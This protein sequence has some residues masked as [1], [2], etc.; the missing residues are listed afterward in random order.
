MVFS[1]GDFVK[2]DYSIWRQADRM[3]IYT[4][5]KKL[6]EENNAFDN[7]TTYGPQLVVVGK[8]NVIKGVDSAIKSMGVSESRKLELEPKDAFG[9][10]NPD[11]IKV[12]P[13]NDFRKKDI[14]PY[15][16]MQ[17]D[18]DG[19][20][21]T[22]KSV[23][24]GRVTVDANHPLAGEKL[25]CEIK[26]TEKVDKDDDKATALAEKFALK[27]D[28]VAITGSQIKFVFG[29]KTDKGSKYLVSKTDLVN[30]TM[31]YMDKIDRIVVEE[32]FA[33]PKKDEQKGSA[34]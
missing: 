23:T 7:E 34:K 19:S 14:A 2:I 28:S 13:L 20:V 24:S 10:K 29:D 8:G 12:M 30:A 11:L 22:V 27:P 6:A 31:A 26:V 32:E 1:D 33:R 16:G 3:L 17:L 4:T 15:P 9:D 18:L 25:T 21:A 5:S